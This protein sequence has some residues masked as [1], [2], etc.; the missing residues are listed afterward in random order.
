MSQNLSGL[1]I[2]IL[3]LLSERPMHPY[4]M[5]QT[6]IERGE[7]RLIKVRAGSLYHKVSALQN[8]GLVQAISTSR[9]GNRPERTTYKITAEGI[10]A[11]QLV[12]CE[13]VQWPI[14]EYPIFPVAIAEMH[15][16]SGDTAIRALHG[17]IAAVEADQEAYLGHHGAVQAKE[18]PQRYYLEIEYTLAMIGA[19]LT[20]LR[21]TVDQLETGELQWQ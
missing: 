21:T 11:L 7:D 17:R 4:E 9:A 2:A 20:W 10:D 5:H 12:V 18:L 14:N 19:E 15:N 6:M 13:R 1:A 8:A 3:A 16:L